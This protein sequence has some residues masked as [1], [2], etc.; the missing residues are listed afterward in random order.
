ML[1]RNQELHFGPVTFKLLITYLSGDVQG[2]SS[3][4]LGIQG[5]RLDIG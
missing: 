3:Y 2:A 1:D 4:E 5:E